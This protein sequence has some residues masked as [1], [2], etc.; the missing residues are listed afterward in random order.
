MR[1]IYDLQQNLNIALQAYSRLATLYMECSA[2]SAAES[3]LN[4]LEGLIA[5]KHSNDMTELQQR[6]QEAH[7]KGSQR[8]HADYYK[9][10]GIQTSCDVEEVGFLQL[11]L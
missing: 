7:L 5:G 3:V 11:L 4:Q 9:L 1:C 8:K 10:L 2:F 6:K